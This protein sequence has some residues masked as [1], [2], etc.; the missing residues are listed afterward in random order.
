MKVLVLKSALR[1]NQ[2]DGPAAP[3]IFTLCEADAM[4]LQ[5]VQNSFNL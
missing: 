3:N 2:R 1:A 4:Q 5:P